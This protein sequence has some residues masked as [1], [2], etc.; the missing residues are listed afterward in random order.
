[1]RWVDEEACS[2]LRATMFTPLGVFLR[3][4]S[5]DNCSFSSSIARIRCWHVFD[6]CLLVF[7]FTHYV[8]V[9]VLGVGTGFHAY[10]LQKLIFWCCRS[11]LI[12]KLLLT[13]PM[14]LPTYETLIPL[15]FVVRVS[16]HSDI[17]S[18][19]QAEATPPD[20]TTRQW[21][22]NPQ[23]PQILCCKCSKEEV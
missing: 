7:M 6:V 23:P 14:Y 9:V 5:E 15:P 22:L 3:R 8:V 13:S 10:V 12:Y 2:K 4:S 20:L 17:H 18:H 21:V 16:S 1:M 19:S 11:Y